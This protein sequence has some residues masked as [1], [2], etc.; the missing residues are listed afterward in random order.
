[1]INKKIFGLSIGLVA[2]VLIAGCNQQETT[3][4]FFRIAKPSTTPT[5]I[6]CNTFILNPDVYLG[7]TGQYV[8]KDLGY[9]TCV[10]LYNADVIS[11]GSN[12]IEHP[13]PCTGDSVVINDL[14]A[15]GNIQEGRYT[16]SVSCCKL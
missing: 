15:R 9:Q 3:G 5:S 16:H 13:V 4:Q 11:G 6:E 7:K 12:R 2:L 10:T 14:V 8:C 1:M